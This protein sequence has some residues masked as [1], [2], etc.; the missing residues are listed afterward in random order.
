M[1]ESP[2]SLMSSSFTFL[3]ET[4]SEKSLWKTNSRNS[5]Q[6]TADGFSDVSLTKCQADVKV[7]LIGAIE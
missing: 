6:A 1:Q 3:K 2:F 4:S 5:D 7:N